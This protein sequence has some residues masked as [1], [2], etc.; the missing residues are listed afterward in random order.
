MGDPGVFG[1]AKR[2]IRGNLEAQWGSK[3]PPE[4]NEDRAENGRQAFLIRAPGRMK[5]RDPAPGGPSR[6]RM[7]VGWSRGVKVG[8][9]QVRCSAT[10]TRAPVVAFE[11]RAGQDADQVLAGPQRRRSLGG[12]GVGGK[13]KGGGMSPR[14]YASGVNGFNL[15]GP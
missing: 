8:V 15:E 13:R 2:L 7:G 4:S 10:R 3:L 5:L 14:L 11:D 1:V 6:R 12:A 9:S